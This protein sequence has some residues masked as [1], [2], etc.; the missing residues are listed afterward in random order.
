MERSEQQRK[1][2][3]LDW[4]REIKNEGKGKGNYYMATYF[5]MFT[6][7]G[8]KCVFKSVH[9]YDSLK[10]ARWKRYKRVTYISFLSK[11]ISKKSVWPS[12]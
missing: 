4:N 11:E 2:P 6:L 10:Q 12:G 3:S 5:G 1:T 9:S 8:E 7:I